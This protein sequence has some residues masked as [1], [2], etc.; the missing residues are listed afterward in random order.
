[1]E[2]TVGRETSFQAGMEDLGFYLN[3]PWGRGSCSPA[4]ALVHSQCIVVSKKVTATDSG[5]SPE[6]QTLSY[7]CLDSGLLTIPNLFIE[8]L[9][10]RLSPGISI[11][12]MRERSWR[13]FL[14][15]H[16]NYYSWP[17]PFFY[18]WVHKNEPFVEGFLFSETIL[19]L[20]AGWGFLI[21][22][23]FQEEY[24]A[25]GRWHLR[26]LSLLLAITVVNGLAATI[27]T[28]LS[29]YHDT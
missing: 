11:P 7:L 29:S 1:M 19:H 28:W 5:A 18:S 14:I 17:Y 6:D 4:E 20:C 3:L 21:Q 24:G 15:F 25:G 22:W 27:L 2:K 9:Q 16:F 23:Y 12:S 13:C 10:P 8:N 26:Q